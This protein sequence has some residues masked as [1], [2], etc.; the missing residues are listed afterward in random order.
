MRL[1]CVPLSR[2]TVIIK[3]GKCYKRCPASLA[4][5]VSLA[6]CESRLPC[7]KNCAETASDRSDARSDNAGPSPAAKQG[8]DTAFPGSARQD[9][10][11][12]GA[13]HEASKIHF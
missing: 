10:L 3:R 8:A 4:I 13:H 7:E 5:L 12:K 1:A 9:Y 6:K 11:K 2:C